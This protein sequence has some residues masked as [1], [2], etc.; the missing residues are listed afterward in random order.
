MCGP[1]DSINIADQ[2]VARLQYGCYAHITQSRPLYVYEYALQKLAM[3]SAA[4]RVITFD[5]IIAIS[6][7]T[8]LMFET[9]KH[10]YIY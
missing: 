1:S 10:A 8:K 3:H 7:Y 4:S 5:A 9:N 6:D 2:F